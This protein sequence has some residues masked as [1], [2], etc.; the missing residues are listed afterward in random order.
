MQRYIPEYHV[1]IDLIEL[2][3]SQF[4]ILDFYFLFSILF[5]YRILSVS[6]IFMFFL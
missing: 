5:F 4:T 6:R 2:Y 1:F 3:I